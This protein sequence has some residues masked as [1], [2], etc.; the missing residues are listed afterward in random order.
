M[1]AWDAAERYLSLAEFRAMVL[2][3]MYLPLVN[4]EAW[5]VRDCMAAVRMVSVCIAWMVSVVFVARAW[6][7]LSQGYTICTMF[8]WQCQLGTRLTTAVLACPPQ[9]AYLFFRSLQCFMP[10]V[11]VIVSLPSRRHGPFVSVPVSVPVC[12]SHDLPRQG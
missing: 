4:M 9:R 11:P 1:R 12:L 5:E 10:F 7:M 2:D 3:P 8:S 6:C